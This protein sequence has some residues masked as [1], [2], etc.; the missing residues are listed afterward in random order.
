MGG[1]ICKVF[2][3][4]SLHGDNQ[5]TSLRKCLLWVRKG[6]CVRDDLIE[7]SFKGHSS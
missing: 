5:E 4:Y 2:S 3:A 7:F 6:L 1:K